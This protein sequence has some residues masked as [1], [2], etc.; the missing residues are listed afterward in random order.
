MPKYMETFAMSGQ[1]EPYQIRDK[2]AARAYDLNVKA[3]NHRG[4]STE[5]PENTIPAYIMSKNKGFTYV[6]ADVSFT[7][8]GVAVLLH[9]A[10]IDRTSD[11]TGNISSMTYEYALQ[12]DF[13]SWFSAEYA[14]VKIPT[15]TEFV[16]LCK[17][18][19]LHPYIELKSNGSYTQSRR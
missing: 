7:S 14:G 18:L 15:F 3:I 16:T 2:E 4:F 13:G 9:D 8:D 5:A 19:G 10:T 12:Y 1:S 6:E 11:G 17:R